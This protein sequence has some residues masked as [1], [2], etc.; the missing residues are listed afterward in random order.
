MTREVSDPHTAGGTERI[1]RRGVRI[2]GLPP[3]PPA[4]PE[5]RARRGR[6]SRWST[7]SAGHP[8]ATT[9]AELSAL[10]EHLGSCRVG[11]RRSAL[12]CGVQALRTFAAAHVV[13]CVAAVALVIA[14]AWRLS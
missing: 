14:L 7:A 13:T 9:P 3:G 5:A 2:T 11:P 10:G 12:H 4:R 8:A 6:D 1:R